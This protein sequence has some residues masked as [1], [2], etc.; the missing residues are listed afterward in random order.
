MKAKQLIEML[1][2]LEDYE[3]KDC[4]LTHEICEALDVRENVHSEWVWNPD[5]IDF[6][7]GAWVCKRCGC[8]NENI[9][10]HID[11]KPLSWAGSFYCP[12]CGADMRTD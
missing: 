6:G 3:L 7:I 4:G 9:P 2:G 1:H 11:E 10:A 5:A 12:N 8:R